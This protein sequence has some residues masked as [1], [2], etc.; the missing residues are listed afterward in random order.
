M[1]F[2]A[3]GFKDLHTDETRHPGLLL[4]VTLKNYLGSGLR[5]NKPLGADFQSIHFR[6]LG[7]KPRVVRYCLE[8]SRKVA[9]KE[10]VREKSFSIA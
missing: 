5:R 6:T 10:V 9:A 2:L 7:F 8:N 1:K 3:R 4:R